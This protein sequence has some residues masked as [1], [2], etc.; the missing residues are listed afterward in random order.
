MSPTRGRMITNGT[1]WSANEQ[2]EME[3]LQRIPDFYSDQ[4]RRRTVRH[5]SDKRLP[6]V[7]MDIGVTT[8]ARIQ[9]LSPYHKFFL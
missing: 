2:M 4:R 3:L 8:T 7:V 5:Q 1:S 9:G 6:N